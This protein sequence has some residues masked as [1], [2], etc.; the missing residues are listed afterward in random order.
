MFRIKTDET[1]VDSRSYLKNALTMFSTKC[2]F[3]FSKIESCIQKVPGSIA[4][5][6]HYKGSR[7]ESDAKHFSL[8][9]QSLS[10]QSS[11]TH[12]TPCSW[13]HCLTW[14]KVINRA[15]HTKRPEITFAAEV[16]KKSCWLSWELFWSA[17]RWKPSPTMK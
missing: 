2:D 17:L 1:F 12:V 15:D 16:V 10:P 13:S 4:G 3:F 7:V 11:Y 8:T 14:W 6:T 9:P 5:I